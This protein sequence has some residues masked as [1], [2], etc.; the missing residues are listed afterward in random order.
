MCVCVREKV[1]S[2]EREGNDVKFTLMKKNII[3]RV[4]WSPWGGLPYWSVWIPF[5]F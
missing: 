3:I 5:L 1:V 4:R 2:L